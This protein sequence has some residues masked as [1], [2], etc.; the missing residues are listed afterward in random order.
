MS[1]TRR[2]DD[3]RLSA[4]VL[5]R[6]ARGPP[7]EARPRPP[8]SRPLDRP[9]TRRPAVR[10]APTATRRGRRAAPHG[11]QGRPPR[12]GPDRLDRPAR[13]IATRGARTTRR[14]GRP[15]GCS[16]RSAARPRDGPAHGRPPADREEDEP[17]ALDPSTTGRPEDGRGRRRREVPRPALLGAQGRHDRPGRLAPRRWP[18]PPRGAADACPLSDGRRGPRGSRSIVIRT[19]GDDP[20][21]AR[22]TT[23]IVRPA[24]ND[25]DDAF[26]GAITTPSSSMI[27]RP[28]SL[29][30]G[31]GRGRREPSTPGPG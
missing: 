4:L 9:A 6:S 24:G 29:R 5:S 17:G 25:M 2:F 15:S 7:G 27:C 26:V 28:I 16:R 8:R 14:P 10:D 13:V 20:D 19:Q 18:R 11:C 22:G 1:S 12:D 23:P 31:R 21:P 3:G 30:R